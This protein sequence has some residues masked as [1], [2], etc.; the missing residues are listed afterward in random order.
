MGKPGPTVLFAEAAHLHRLM[1]EGGLRPSFLGIFRGASVFDTVGDE[2]RGGGHGLDF[3]LK[4]F[5]LVAIGE[6][7]LLPVLPSE[8]DAPSAAKFRDNFLRKIAT[9]R[10]VR[11]VVLEGDP[12]AQ[13]TAIERLKRSPVDE[14]SSPGWRPADVVIVLTTK[15]FPDVRTAI[16]GVRLSPA[17]ARI[18][19]MTE[20]LQTGREGLHL[21]LADHVWP[22]CV[23]RL[24]AVRACMPADPERASD[25]AAPIHAW[26]TFAWGVTSIEESL[27]EEQYLLALREQL[28]PSIDDES[29][30]I[31]AGRRRHTMIVM[32]AARQPPSDVPNFGWHDRPEDL[33]R[34]ASHAIDDAALDTLLATA[35]EGLATQ[36]IE[37]DKNTSMLRSNAKADWANV[38]TAEGLVHLR[39]L[40]NG[41]LWP[42][43]D[44]R[45]RSE[46][47]E[48]GWRS[49]AERGMRLLESRDRHKQAIEELTIARSHFLPFDWRLIIAAATLCFL[50]QF[51][52]ATLLPLRP[53]TPSQALDGPVFMG[54]PVAGQ[55]VGFLIDRSSS[56]QG[57]KLDTVKQDLARAIRALP[58]DTTFAAIAF[59]SNSMPMPGLD[60]GLVAASDESKQVVIDWL[61]S[62]TADGNTVAGPGLETMLAM[63]PE[64]IVLLTD[65][66]FSDPNAV[67]EAVSKA[68]RE[69]STRIDTVA[70]YGRA[71]EESLRTIAATTQ[72]TYRFVAYDPFSP[73]GFDILIG[74]TIIASVLGATTGLLLPW[75]LERRAGLRAT[76]ALRSSERDLLAALATQAGAAASY[77][78]SAAGVTLGRRSNATAALQASLAR[79]ALTAAEQA[80]AALRSDRREPQRL[81]GHEN[82]PGELVA[83]D[84]ADLT[85]AL[86]EPLPGAGNVGEL[87]RVVRELAIEHAASLQIAWRQMCERQDPMATG[88]LPIRAIMEE[89]YAVA[90]GFFDAASMRGIG[91]VTRDDGA[92][93]PLSVLAR[94]LTER[95]LDD[96]HRPFMSAAV[97]ARDGKMPDRTFLWVGIDAESGEGHVA[98]EWLR[99]HVNDRVPITAWTEVNNLG[100]TALALIQ[101]E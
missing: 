16:E 29:D 63:R 92:S 26:R 98:G 94:T 45:G 49:L 75:W 61:N 36:W 3:L 99:D 81:A 47:Q 76:A 74:L 13:V 64:S 60:D 83:E 32:E 27:W 11:L 2:P 6:N 59:S 35:A 54:L 25:V 84:R 17:V 41:R 28:L 82:R 38:A 50:L 30:E 9:R 86:D 85:A 93:A 1:A 14:R 56:M 78:R 91:L 18:Y 57:K 51:M 52:L 53:P 37:R 101:E 39:R 46:S 42:T 43:V 87:N 12:T 72:G 48:N 10:Q 71:G 66:E 69:G 44:V 88:H 24:L 89:F 100:I 79:R 7:L 77:A 70:L 96:S 55:T 73:P 21:A 68:A 31:A 15:L 20:R 90:R 40:A 4:E 22:I 97:E 8:P 19:L 95:L 5:P 65:G 58:S 33:G 67:Q 34:Q 62:L 23:A 80:V